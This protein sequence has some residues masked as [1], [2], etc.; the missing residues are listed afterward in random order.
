MTIDCTQCQEWEICPFHPKEAEPEHDTWPSGWVP[1]PGP[2]P[3]CRRPECISDHLGP[4]GDGLRLLGKDDP[5]VSDDLIYATPTGG[6]V[7]VP[8]RSAR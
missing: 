6:V 7:A 2:D 5:E 8:D 4:C 1:P 3:R